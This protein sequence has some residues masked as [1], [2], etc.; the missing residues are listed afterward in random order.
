MGSDHD[1]NHGRVTKALTSAVTGSCQAKQTLKALTDESFEKM[2]QDE[3]Q[4]SVAAASC[5]PSVLC[6]EQLQALG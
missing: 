3:A 5:H 6:F 4:R 2:E 1:D